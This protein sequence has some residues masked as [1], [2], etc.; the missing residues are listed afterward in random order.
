[1]DISDD[2][3][4]AVSHAALGNGQ[5]VWLAII[6]VLIYLVFDRGAEA[7]LVMSSLPLALIGGIW[8]AETSGRKMAG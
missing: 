7:W 1:M 8:L 2:G 6:F 4:T 5:D 3:W